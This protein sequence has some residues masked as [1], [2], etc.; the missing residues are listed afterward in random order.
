M[1]RTIA[2]CLTL[3]ACASPNPESASASPYTQPPIAERPA[4]G[5][6]LDSPS[7]TIGELLCKAGVYVIAGALIL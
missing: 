4:C 7:T 5:E 2:L 6:T 3:A 1:T